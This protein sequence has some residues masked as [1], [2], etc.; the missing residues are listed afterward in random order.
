MTKPEP[1]ATY[2][3][4]VT[5]AESIRSGLALPPGTIDLWSQNRTADELLTTADEI[6]AEVT[7]HQH[8]KT[9]GHASIRYAFPVA[10]GGARITLY[11]TSSDVSEQAL[12]K[13]AAHNAECITDPA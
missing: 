11:T 1:T 10:P 4:L 8:S 3:A 13:Y 7:V 2:N 5:I 6:G 12:K 9:H